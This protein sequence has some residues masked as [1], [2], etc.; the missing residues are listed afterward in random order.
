M[1]LVFRVKLDLLKCLTSSYRLNYYI[2][3]TNSVLI[4][5]LIVHTLGLH[6]I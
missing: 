6:E 1:G 4:L 2:L 3:Y 5:I